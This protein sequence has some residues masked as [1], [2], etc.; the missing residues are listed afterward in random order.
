MRRLAAA[1]FARWLVSAPA[2]AAASRRSPGNPRSALPFPA[3]SASLDIVAATARNARQIQETI[4]SRENR[5][6]KRFRSAL[7][8]TPEEGAPIGVEGPRLVEEAFRSRLHV[9]ALLVSSAGERHLS[10]LK[11]YLDAT[12]RLLRCSDRLFAS[13]S[14]TEAPKGIAA[15]VHHHSY[16][17][18]DLLAGNPLVVILVGVQS[19]QFPRAMDIARPLRAAGVQVCLGGFHVSGSLSMLPGVTPELQEAMDLGIS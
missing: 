2:K 12:V 3:A 14:G 17:W 9:E 1:G 16:R 4:E 18:E 10:R 6:L 15:L 19:N 11:P 13:A 7:R 5:W 8:D